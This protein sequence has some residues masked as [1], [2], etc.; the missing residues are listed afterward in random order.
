MKKLIKVLAG[1]VIAL[2]VLVLVAALTLPLYIGPAVKAAARVGGPAALGVPVSIGDVKLRPL[3][4]VLTITQVKIGN[5]EGYS[6]GEAF[7]VEKVEIGLKTASL[8]SDTIVVKKVLIAAPAIGFESKDGKSNFDAMLANAKKNAAE[9]NAKK[10]EQKRTSKKMVIEEFTLNGAK[11]S[12]TSSV[13]FGKPVTLPLPPLTLRDIGKASGGAT[14][15]DALT[16]IVN[17]IVGGLKQLISDL[18]GS[19]NDLM[20]GSLK[21]AGDLTKSAEDAAKGATDAAKDAA[22]SATDAAKSLKKLFK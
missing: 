3:L 11:V 17:G 19:A 6:K 15:A 1:V 16:E 18:A 12:Y 10:P 2:V 21:G 9:Q 20:K 5:P 13:T 22:K 4:G 8:F 14:A 7:A